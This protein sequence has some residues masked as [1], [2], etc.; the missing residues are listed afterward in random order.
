MM[1]DLQGRLPW[2]DGIQFE[3]KEAG[4][5]ISCRNTRYPTEDGKVQG[6]YGEV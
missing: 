5:S 2:Y 3:S 4:R 1:R 6:G